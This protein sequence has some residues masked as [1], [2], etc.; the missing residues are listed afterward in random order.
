MKPKQNNTT[1]DPFIEAITILQKW[2]CSEVDQQSLLGHIQDPM[3]REIIQRAE[4]IVSIDASLNILFSE[5]KSI[6]GWINKPNSLNPFNGDTPL[7]HIKTAGDDGLKAVSA[8]L[9]ARSAGNF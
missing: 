2:H 5:L 8:F 9:G 3:D 4:L 6:N 1:E 7:N